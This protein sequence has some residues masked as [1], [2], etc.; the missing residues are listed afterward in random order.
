M[1]SGFIQR[2]DLITQVRWNVQLQDYAN[3]I[4]SSVHLR[5]YLMIVFSLNH[6]KIPK[7]FYPKVDVTDLIVEIYIILEFLRKLEEATFCH[8]Q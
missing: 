4:C 7:H 2:E 6:N 8:R 1:D 5:V 3:F